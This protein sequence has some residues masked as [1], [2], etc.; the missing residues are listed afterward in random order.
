MKIV[1][2]N[3]FSGKT[4]FYTIASR[5]P[6]RRSKRVFKD[7]FIVGASILIG[8]LIFVP[9]VLRIELAKKSPKASKLQIEVP[10][11]PPN[12][13]VILADDLGELMCVKFLP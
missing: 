4:Y 1:S 5:E 8:V 7:V 10:T 12:I 13:I 3:R 11:K 6:P 9:I 2:E